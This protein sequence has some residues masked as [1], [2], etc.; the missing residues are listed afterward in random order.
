VAITYILRSTN[1]DLG[2]G[3]D[4]TKEITSGAA[5]TEATQSVS[6]ANLATESSLGFTPLGT[7]GA[8]GT[9]TGSFTVEVRIGSTGSSVITVRPFLARADAS[10]NNLSSE[11]A[12]AQA[13]Q[14]CTANSTFTFTWS[15]PA[16]GT[17]AAGDRLKVIYVFVSSQTM[18]GAAS[19]TVS[20]N[21][22]N[23][24]VITPFSV[25]GA[26]LESGIAG[27]SSVTASTLVL[28]SAALASAIAGASAVTADLTAGGGGGGSAPTIA[29]TPTNGS[30]VSATSSF[31]VT[32]PTGRQ[33]TEWGLVGIGSS[34]GS[35]DTPSGWTAGLANSDISNPHVF[36]Y[37]RKFDGSESDTLA[38]TKGG[39]TQNLGWVAMRIAGADAT[40]FN[41]VSAVKFSDALATATSL[42]MDITTSTDHALVIGLVSVN[43]SSAAITPPGT[44]TE[45]AEST[46]GRIIEA[47][48]LDKTPAGS[49][50][51]LTWTWSGGRATAGVI[52]A[53][54]P[55]GG[56]GGAAVLA[57]AVSGG[58]TVTADLTPGLHTWRWYTDATPD[59]SMTAL[60][61]AVVAPVLTGA[62]TMGGIVRLRVQLTASVSALHM[63]YSVDGTN[64]ADIPNADN[65]G[66]SNAQNRWFLWANGAATAGGTIGTQLLAGTQASGTY[67]E[68]RGQSLTVSGGN[69]TEFDL[70]FKVRW[71]PPATTVLIRLLD[72]ATPIT[73]PTA[74]SL[75]TCTV[76]NRSHTID[77]ADANASGGQNREVNHS[78]W[79]RMFHDG[80][81]WW[82]F[83][84]QPETST[85]QIAYYRWTGSGA[86]SK[87]T[88][89][90]GA[91]I[92]T[93]AETDVKHAP[94]MRTISGTPVAGIGLFP[95]SG[96]MRYL[97]GYVSGSSI[98]W[99]SVVDIGAARPGSQ[100]H[101]C[102]DQGGFHWVAGINGTTGVWARRS[103]AADDGSTGYVPAFGSQ[104]SLTD[105]GVAAGNIP[106][107]IPLA[108]N[109]VLMIWRNGTKLRAA[110]VTG[111]GWGTAADATAAATTNTDDWGA[112]LAGDGFVYLVHSDSTS[113]GGTWRT[114]RYNVGTPG[115]S[116]GTDPGA[117]QPSQNSNADGIV[118]TANSTS[119]V[120]V[121]G[122]TEGSETGQ[123]RTI[124]AIHWNGSTW[125][126][127][128]KVTPAGG[129]GNGDDIA[130]P[131]VAAA[132]AIPILY[133]HGDDDVSGKPF[134]YEY[135]VLTVAATHALAAA[136][137]G[138]SSVTAT[139]LT[140]NH[141][142][143]SAAA[144]SSAATALRLVLNHALASAVSGSSTVTATTL[145]LPRAL[146]ATVTGSSAVTATTLTLNHAMAAAVSG[147]GT[148]TADLT[149]AGGGAV[150]ASTISG[151]SAVTA[152]RLS[153]D[154]A[155]SATVT[156]SSAATASS[157]A[158][159]HAL[160]AAVAGAGT[161]SAD[162]SVA[163]SGAVLAST[164]A[165]GSTVMAS[166]L[167]LNHPLAAAVAGGSA[168]SATTVRV[169][170]PLIAA[171][172][173]AA[174]VTAD[175]SPAG[176][177]AVLAATVTG[178][179]AVAASGLRLN[180]A[181][182]A[183]IAGASS[184]SATRITVD[185]ILLA[186]ILGGSTA[187]AT[188]I[189]V[190]HPL[191]AAISGGS[192]VT[193]SNIR[194]T[195]PLAAA[196]AGS[197]T[198]TADM[199]GGVQIIS[200]TAQLGGSGVG[201]RFANAGMSG[202]LA[203]S[204]NG[205]S[206]GE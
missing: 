82:T 118:V 23:S 60:A 61:D 203:T 165:G 186:A 75:T 116:A 110:E 49:T 192:A 179:S 42:G 159:N 155:L 65:S 127:L 147:T 10:G 96:N 84:T 143:A 204:R 139:A 7:P 178:G 16:L 206:L 172:S 133:L 177:G 76:A 24:E 71:P 106:A 131:P 146:V 160:V 45:V 108:S 13:A 18:G 89:D 185:H 12:P 33:T 126:A 115:W 113:T 140:L 168:A 105:S 51:T 164:I 95:S 117:A 202:R 41:D 28:P 40:T 8:N 6:V 36:W 34:G 196:L 98:T 20:F 66:V 153:L 120:Y 26:V 205:G 125:A 50:G 197:S 69:R 195:S 191:L 27:G 132:G 154:H 19:V 87:A 9:S 171:A 128:G 103:T 4:F 124:D 32:L 109:R 68:S 135:H 58:S 119:D 161:V 142:L 176:A 130:G 182:A 1:S 81:A 100:S 200:W 93:T 174:T 39:G 94:W 44:L 184:T 180:H 122:T 70:A 78:A 63:E 173:G 74:I 162:L 35:I 17:W 148:V 102:I 86:W 37:Y 21:T 198:L 129:R 11:I 138:G 199:I 31:N 2:G 73:L 29:G 123:D 158:V 189:T 156:G 25:G 145:N 181:L 99:A 149:P 166:R 163:G 141:A 91:N 151:S 90:A 107:L 80:T 112:A 194:V 79:P 183:A 187:S 55:A 144:G 114:R 54:K 170:H 22:A 97:R 5:T 152:S 150:L 72:G 136:V 57:A 56:G 38:M 190:S 52:L 46:A 62:Q 201:G 67:I 121:F 188:S 134:T 101:A 111:S 193:A 77:K 47:A 3:A 104:L 30:D 137:A 167:T 48:V 88:V 14:T 59:G 64:W 169:N 85:S 92:V 15:S 43:S 83:V 53:V 157:I 175:L